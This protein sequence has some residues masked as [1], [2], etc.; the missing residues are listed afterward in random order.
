M[1]ERPRAEERALFK[2]N[3][4]AMRVELSDNTAEKLLQYRDL[5][6]KWNRAYNLTSIK[7]PED[8]LVL[9]VLDSLSILPRVSAFF[10]NRTS[11][12]LLDAGSGGG[13]PGIPLG[14]A[15][16]SLSVTL[17]DS[18]GKKTAF[19]R[20][21]I[22]EL[23]LSNVHAEHG[24]AEQFSGQFDLIVSRAFANLSDFVS[25]S[26]ALLAPGGRWLAMKGKDS[27]DEQ[28]ALSPRIQVDE[29]IPLSIPGMRAERHLVILS[30]A[31]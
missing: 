25:C 11:L 28:R 12:S 14:A 19:Q 2:K 6:M 5:L 26:F 27:A 29:V 20:Q 31:S 24:R 17:L 18:V 7:S 1:T 9:H 10:E 8:A 30:K 3:A 13:L 22:I 4:A 16:P 15:L 21:A 23:G